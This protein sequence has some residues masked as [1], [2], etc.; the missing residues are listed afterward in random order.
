M[1]RRRE[2]KE[3]EG[4]QERDGAINGGLDNW[5]KRK[6]F[7]KRREKM[8]PCRPSLKTRALPEK[9]LAER[10][11]KKSRKNML[12]GVQPKFEFA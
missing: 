3:R 4:K 12:L 7:T 8:T 5:T 6:T 10:G 2:R 1:G 11:G 9:G